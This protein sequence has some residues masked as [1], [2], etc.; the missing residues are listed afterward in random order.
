MERPEPPIDAHCIFLDQTYSLD[1]RAN[2]SSLG[3]TVC[4]PASPVPGLARI[5]I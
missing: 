3:S 5:L 4:H 2:P 1:A